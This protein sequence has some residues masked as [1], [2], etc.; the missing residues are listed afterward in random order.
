VDHDADY[1]PRWQV[2]DAVQ[3]RFTVP[4]VIALHSARILTGGLAPRA[5]DRRELARMA[6]LPPRLGRGMWTGA[7]RATPFA[8]VAAAS[9]IAQSGVEPVGH[10]MTANAKRLRRRAAR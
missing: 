7:A 3:I 5:D 1:A 2:V 4:Q 9:K 10:R 8:A 6:L